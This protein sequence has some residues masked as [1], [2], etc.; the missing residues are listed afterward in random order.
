MD[1]CVG[2]QPID[3]RSGSQQSQ[4]WQDA[5]QPYRGGHQFEYNFHS[6]CTNLFTCVFLIYKILY[7]NTEGEN[8]AQK[9]CRAERIIQEEGCPPTTT[10]PSDISDLPQETNM[11]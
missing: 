8:V 3:G 5:S 10:Y 7:I 1:D 11:Q 4:G 9:K 2:S 6:I